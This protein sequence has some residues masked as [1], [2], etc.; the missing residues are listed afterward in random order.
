MHLYQC[1]RQCESKSY[2][3]WVCMCCS[4]VKQRREGMTTHCNHSSP[5]YAVLSQAVTLLGN[6]K[7]VWWTTPGRE[8]VW[9]FKHILVP[10]PSL[11]WP[12]PKTRIIQPHQVLPCK[13]HWRTYQT[14]HAIYLEMLTASG[15]HHILCKCKRSICVYVCV[16]VCLMVMSKKAE[17]EKNNT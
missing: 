4:Q 6:P 2:S 3:M 10:L 11:W 13:L 14:H 7:Q 5:N 1:D 12:I 15:L 17:Q 8:K 16:C 9:W